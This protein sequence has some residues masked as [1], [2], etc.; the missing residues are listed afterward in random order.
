VFAVAE[1]QVNSFF[2]FKF[3]GNTGGVLIHWHFTH[4]GAQIF[5]QLCFLLNFGDLP[6]F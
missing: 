4:E 3:Q 2:V 6:R 1:E 5:K